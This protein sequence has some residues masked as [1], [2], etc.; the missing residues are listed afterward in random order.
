MKKLSLFLILFECLA[1][2]CSAQLEG[3]EGWK[4]LGKITFVNQ[5][6]AET[7]DVVYTPIYSKSLKALAGKEIVLRGYVLP[8]P[9]KDGNFILSAFPFSSCYYCGGAGPETV[10]EVSPKIPILARSGKPIIIKGRLRL[11]QP[12]DSLR[13]PFF[14]IDAELF[15]E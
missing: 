3:A 13:L 1:L 8:I 5:L 14:L 9:A 15:S 12:F 7:G 11:N 10:I 2:A 4:S 6:N